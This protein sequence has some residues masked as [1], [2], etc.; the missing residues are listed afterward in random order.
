MVKQIAAIIHTLTLILSFI[1]YDI[2][3]IKYPEGVS[4][5]SKS[6]YLIVTILGQN[7]TLVGLE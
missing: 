5:K 7:R 2:K 3:K 1:I 4:S 6:N